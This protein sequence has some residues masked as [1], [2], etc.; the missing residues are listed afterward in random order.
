MPA[1]RDFMTTGEAAEFCGFTIQ[2]VR[3]LVE[4]G[5]IPATNTSCGTRP[6]WTIRREDLEAF[7]SPTNVRRDA[8]Q[9]AARRRTRRIDADVPQIF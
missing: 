4:L 1:D 7:L 3:R 2:K 8:T 5:R 6:R 9:S